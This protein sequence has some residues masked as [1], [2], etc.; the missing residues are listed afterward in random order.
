MVPAFPCTKF[1]LCDVLFVDGIELDKESLVLL[2]TTSMLRGNKQQAMHLGLPASVHDL[3][4]VLLALLEEHLR[5]LLRHIDR[6]D[7]AS[8]LDAES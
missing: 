5:L 7:V 1:A 6:I 8:R 2:M 3:A 4:T